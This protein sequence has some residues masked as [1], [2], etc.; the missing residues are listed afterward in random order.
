MLLEEAELREIQKAAR[1]ERVTV[2]EWVRRAL[3]Q[4]RK[5][6]PVRDTTRKLDAIRHATQHEFPTADIDRMLDEIE[7]G[8][9]GVIE[10]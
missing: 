4:A 10:P 9:A 7:R 6:G 2:A 8:R 3:R 5:E 1:R